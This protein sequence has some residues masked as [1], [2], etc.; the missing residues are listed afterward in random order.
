V[1]ALERVSGPAGGAGVFAVASRSHPGRTYRVVW[2]D[3]GLFCPCPGY[4]FRG[5]C[6]H[7]HA[8]AVAIA[9]ERLPRAVA[10]ARRLEEIAKEL[11]CA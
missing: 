3:L 6:W 11:D 10:A 8:V 7:A 5:A 1:R 4:G 9:Q 2:G